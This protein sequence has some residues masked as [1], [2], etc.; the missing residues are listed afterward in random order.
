MDARD[1]DYPDSKQD[2]RASQPMTPAIDQAAA[3]INWKLIFLL[4]AF[5]LLQAIVV[6]QEFFRAWPLWVKVILGLVAVP[7]AFAGWI[8]QQVTARYFLHG[9][10]AGLFYGVINSVGWLVI[11]FL[12]DFAEL[13]EASAQ[14]PNLRL[15]TLLL[16][17]IISAPISSLMLGLYYGLFAWVAGKMAKARE[18]K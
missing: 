5:G 7:G 12:T 15:S 11:G 8:V 17:S 9:F 13:R 14:A 10:L 18:V 3:R 4:A 6:S 1:S 2:W 16:T